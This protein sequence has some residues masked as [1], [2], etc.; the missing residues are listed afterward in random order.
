[1]CHHLTPAKN[2]WNSY[3]VAPNRRYTLVNSNEGIRERAT[4][5]AETA[6]SLQH[7]SPHVSAHLMNSMTPF[8]LSAAIMSIS[9]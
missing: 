5:T 3:R 2:G 6:S 1:M 7:P 9:P 4:R 8:P